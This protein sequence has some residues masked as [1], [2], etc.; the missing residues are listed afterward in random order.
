MGLLS[1]F[2]QKHGWRYIPGVVFLLISAYLQNLAPMYLGRVTDALRE[3]EIDTRAVGELLALMMLTAAAVFAVRYTYRFFINGN[4]RNLEAYLRDK[5]FSHLQ[6]MGPVFFHSHKTGDLMAYAVNDVNAV[7]QTFGPALALSVNAVS[8]TAIAVLN[9]AASV[10]GK[11]A[12]FALIPAPAVILVMLLLGG[13]TRKRFKRVQEAFGAISDRV[14]ENISGLRV[15]KAYVQESAESARFETL[16]H[17]ARDANIKMARISAAMGPAVDLCFGI[18]FTVSL[19]YGSSLVRGGSV[20]LG[21]FVAFNGY[22]A[23]IVQPM[24][25]V[26]RIINILSR[27]LASTKRLNAIIQTPAEIADRA[28]VESR[29]SGKKLNHAEIQIKNLCFSY[30]ANHEKDAGNSEVKTD[31]AFQL[32]GVSVHIKP[33]G[34][35]GILGRTGSGKTTLA[36]LLARLYNPPDNT[37]FIDGT[38]ANQ[39][40]LDELRAPMGYVPQD[41]FLFS[42]SIE[43]N[44]R[45]FDPR[46]TRE[47][48][49]KAA[50]RAAI[51]KNIQDFPQGFDTQVGERG[52]S[53]SGGQKQRI[54]IARA[55]IKNPKLLILDDSLSAVDTRTEAEILDAVCAYKEKGASVVLIAHRISAL[56]RCDEIVVLDKGEITERG[57]HEEL[58]KRNGL[59]AAIANDQTKDGEE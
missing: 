47:E 31:G 16:N 15:I 43:E 11:L 54:C 1:G 25:Q 21:D 59:Y 50:E 52:M 42:A 37:I 18:S 41:N 13:E 34:L 5:L 4:G 51:L 32:R 3:P 40:S 36:N 23:L 56:S 17:N 48:V 39:L 2:I 8:L 53:L 14:Q 24:R 30:P 58:L 55:L 44:I 27:G 38:D 7:R 29:A 57:T 35:L 9:M 26:S 45:F 10:N 20:S 33:G 19:L 12:A 28:S 6:T 49:E 46:H 22:L